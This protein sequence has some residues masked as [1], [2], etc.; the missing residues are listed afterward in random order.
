MVRAENL[1]RFEL[2]KWEK[3]TGKK[4]TGKARENFIKSH[5]ILHQLN[6]NVK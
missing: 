4:L 2:R 1:A 5:K 6:H 3:K